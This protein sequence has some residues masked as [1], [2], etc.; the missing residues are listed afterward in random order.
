[1]TDGSRRQGDPPERP[2]RERGGDNERRGGI[3]EKGGK[4]PSNPPPPPK[5]VD[6]APSNKDKG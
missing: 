1:M 3:I 2:G 4:Q 6:K 5:P